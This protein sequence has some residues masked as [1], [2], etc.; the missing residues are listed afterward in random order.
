MGMV[1]II[2]KDSLTALD[3]PHT[4]ES[5]IVPM[6][7]MSGGVTPG[8]LYFNEAPVV[9]QADLLQLVEGGYLPDQ[10][11]ADRFETL[12]EAHAEDQRYRGVRV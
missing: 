9:D 8:W 6:N 4:G 10:W 12:V 7:S 2:T 1:V 11:W 3:S 5:A